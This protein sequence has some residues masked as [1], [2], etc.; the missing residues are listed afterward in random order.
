MSLSSDI[1]SYVRG[2]IAKCFTNKSEKV[3]DVIFSRVLPE[4][5]FK[6]DSSNL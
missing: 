2:D 3:R 6:V 4:D 1:Y 5:A